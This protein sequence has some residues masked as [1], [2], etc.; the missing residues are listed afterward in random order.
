LRFAIRDWKPTNAVRLSIA[1]GL[2]LAIAAT[3]AKANGESSLCSLNALPVELQNRL[4]SEFTIWKIQE[5]PNLRPRAKGR[6]GDQK[7]LECPGIAV[8]RFEGADNSYAVLLVPI[9]NPDAA[10]KLLV[11]TPGASNPADKLKSVEQWDK[12]GASNY[13][14]HQIKIKDFFSPE[15]VRKLHVKTKDGILFVDAGETEY[16]ADIYFWAD[17]HYR[18]E[19][20]DE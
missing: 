7:P 11:F 20:T 4:K 18:H 1:F 14:I 12:G 9:D 8:G 6:W 10:Y 2:L 16:E 15:W 3:P 5:A 13:F 17:G 19:P